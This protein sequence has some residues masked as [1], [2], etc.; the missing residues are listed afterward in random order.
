[1]SESS[2]EIS[3][4]IDEKEKELSKLLDSHQIVEQEKLKLQKEILVLQGKKKDFEISL[5]K[6]SHNIRQISI[7]LKLLKSKFWAARNSGL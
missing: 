1:M 5:S 6:S 2:A 7:E 4:M 3:L